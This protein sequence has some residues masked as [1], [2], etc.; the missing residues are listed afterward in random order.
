MSIDIG[1]EAVARA[2]AWLD[3]G[4]SVHVE[5]AA[6]LRALRAALDA[7]EGERDQWIAHAKAAIWTDSE[8]CKALTE[9]CERLA[10]ERDAA[11]ALVAECAEYLKAGETPRQRMDR[12]HKDVLALMELLVAEKNKVRELKTAEARILSAVEVMGVEA[13]VQAAVEIEREDC[14]READAQVDLAE[15]LAR[16][17][18]QL[19]WSSVAEISRALASPARVIAAAI[20]ARRG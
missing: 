3:K 7:A 2:A 18:D 15:R 6:M 17:A 11:R 5:I 1:K 9:A 12:D 20:R 8:E 13:A 16:D 19:G 4:L 14:A 10:A